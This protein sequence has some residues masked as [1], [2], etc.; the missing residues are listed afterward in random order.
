MIV[1][2]GG[3][4]THCID[5]K[6]QPAAPNGAAFTRLSIVGN[7]CLGPATGFSLDEDSGATLGYTDLV[8][9][10]NTLSTG[11]AA[12]GYAIQAKLAPSGLYSNNTIIGYRIGIESSGTGGSA[13]PVMTGNVMRALNPA[14]VSASPCMI[15]IGSTPTFT[16]NLCTIGTTGHPKYG[17]TLNGNTLWTISG[18]VFVGMESGEVHSI[19]T[20]TMTDTKPMLQAMYTDLDHAASA[21]DTNENLLAT[22]TFPAEYFSLFSGLHFVAF[23]DNTGAGGTKTLRTYWGGTLLG[24]LTISAGSVDW[25]IEGDVWTNKVSLSTQGAYIL[26]YEGTTLE[27]SDFTSPTINTAAGTVELKITCQMANGADACRSRGLVT[28]PFR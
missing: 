20:G 9:S 26:G 17:I 27:L 25:R 22:V 23:G 1:L 6:P 11:D 21:A 12:P 18:N 19:N 5:F 15:A 28:Q 10:G 14:N 2:D 7:H 8:V 3:T 4:G 13:A 24:T 16:N